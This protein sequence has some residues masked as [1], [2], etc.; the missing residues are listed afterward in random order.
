MGHFGKYYVA[1]IVVEA[2]FKYQGQKLIANP[3]LMKIVLHLSQ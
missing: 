1:L 3:N 2:N